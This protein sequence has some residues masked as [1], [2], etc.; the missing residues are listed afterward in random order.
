MDEKTNAPESSEEFAEVTL[1]MLREWWVA[2]PDATAMPLDACHCIVAEPLA[3]IYKRPVTY[4]I[5]PYALIYPPGFSDPAHVSIRAARAMGAKNIP[6]TK[7]VVQLAKKFDDLPPV[8]LPTRT[9][10]TSAEC[11]KLIDKV[12]EIYGQ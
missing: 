8:T 2:H 7:G 1:P 9:P 3:D 5:R 10:L 6:L 4:S 12:L 11:V